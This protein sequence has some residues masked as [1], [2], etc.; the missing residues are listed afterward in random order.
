MFAARTDGAH[1]LPDE[2]HGQLP[3][4]GERLGR[5]LAAGDH[6][7]DAGGVAEVEEDQSAVVAPAVHPPGECDLLALVFGPQFAATVSL[8]HR[9]ESRT[10]PIGGQCEAHGRPPVR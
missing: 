8:Q 2:L 9:A 7:H 5:A 3:G 6:L 4:G 1:D 10:R